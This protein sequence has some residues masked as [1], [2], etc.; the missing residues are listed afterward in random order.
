MLADHVAKRT[1]SALS[2]ALLTFH[3]IQSIHRK[4]FMSMSTIVVKKAT[5]YFIP[6]VYFEAPVS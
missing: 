3:R 5:L 2:A 1:C 6:W 4:F